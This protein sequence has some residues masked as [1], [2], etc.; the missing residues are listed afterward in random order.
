MGLDLIASLVIHSHRNCV[1][2]YQSICF[3]SV[4]RDFCVPPFPPYPKVSLFKISFRLSALCL[5]WWH[6]TTVMVGNSSSALTICFRSGI[7]YGYVDLSLAWWSMKTVCQSWLRKRH[8]PG[9]QIIAVLLTG[10]SFRE[11]QRHPNQLFSLKG[12]PPA[13][14]KGF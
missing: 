6:G 2:A 12:I 5:M 1:A 8:P 4:L 14:R 11:L 13:G 7:S 9:F 3:D 10:L